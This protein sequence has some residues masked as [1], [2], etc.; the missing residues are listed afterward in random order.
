MAQLSLKI[1]QLLLDHE[2]PRIS[3]AESQRES[4]QR[5]LNDQGDKLYNLAAS[6]VEVG[7]NPM[8][9]FLGLKGDQEKY[10]ILEGNRR[11]AALKILTNPNVLSNLEIKPALRKRFEDLSKEFNR[12]NV[13]PIPC[14][15]VK[16]RQEGNYWIHLR[17]TGEN[18]GRGIAGWSGLA[19]AR[20]VGKSPALQALQLV[21]DH[22]KLS[23]ELL[24][25]INERFPITTLERLIATPEVRKILGLHLDGEKLVSL[26]ST[27]EILKPLTHIVTELA[28]KKINVTK[29]KS[30]DQQVAYVK[31]F[32]KKYT[33]DLSGA[34]TGV[35]VEELSAPKKSKS[36]ATSTPSK[37]AK[38]TPKERKT[39]IPKT[40]TLNVTNT[41]SA[42]IYSE[43][44]DLEVAKYSHSAAVLLRVFLELSTDH[45]MHRHKMPTQ[46][47]G[48]GKVKATYKPLD[49][50]IREVVDHLS[51]QDGN[52][53][54]HF[55]GV[56]RGLTDNK[57]PLSVEL[58]HAYVHNL[59]VSPS[60]QELMKAWDNAQIFFEKIWP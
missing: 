1:E 5:I 3:E 7:L 11:T 17:H 37:T 45:Y 23:K 26:V 35:A 25:L 22:A 24:A 15:E 29:L 47:K 50:K 2:N 32:D 8:D 51:Q 57:S 59:F 31:G 9:R 52:E 38:S 53:R 28:E 14:V 33:A 30:K 48:A 4:L 19:K 41:K 49:V 18:E 16:S 10:I 21:M 44:Q 46:I 40:C 43:L 36:P 6:I 54:K 13:E 27:E 60:P 42:E 34:G 39:L 55:L 20:F 56:I 12:S 58:L